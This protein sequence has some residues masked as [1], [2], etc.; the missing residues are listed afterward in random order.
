MGDRD[1]GMS[2]R[3]ASEQVIA[4]LV[5]GDRDESDSVIAIAWNLQPMGDAD[6]V[7]CIDLEESPVF[8][9]TDV[10]NA[11]RFAYLHRNL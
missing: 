3:D 5:T 8:P 4:M 9:L 11:A 2:D 10:G 7:T 1:V 6:K